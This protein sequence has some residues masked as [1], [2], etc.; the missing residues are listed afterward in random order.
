MMIQKQNIYA[1]RNVF[2]IQS[3]EREER[4]DVKTEVEEESRQTGENN[5]TGE[6]LK[7]VR[8]EGGVI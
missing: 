8:R 4:S 2:F 1:T 7:E 6:V 5:K 3:V